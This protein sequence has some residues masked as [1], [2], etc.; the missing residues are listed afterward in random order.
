MP[1]VL[2]FFFVTGAPGPWATSS[3]LPPA[4]NATRVAADTAPRLTLDDALQIAL[5]N[6]DRLGAAGAARDAAEA[7][8]GAAK[9]G[10]LPRIDFD[11]TFS[12]TTNPAL[13]FTNRLGQEAF[14]PLDF[15]IDRLNNPDPLT[16]WNSALSLSYPVYTGG[17]VAG[18]LEAARAGLEAADADL[19]RTRQEV[20]RDVVDAFSTA[21]LAEAHLGVARE[22]LETARANVALVSDLRDAGLVVESDLLQAR[23][24]EIEVEEMVIRAEAGVQVARAAV[25]LNLGRDLDTPFSPSPTLEETRGPE[26]SLDEL[27]AEAV[28]NRPDLRAAEAGVRA[29][30]ESRRAARAGSKPEVGL[31]GRFEANDEQFIGAQGTNWSVFVAARIPIYQ[32]KQSRARV[33]RAE[34]Q[35]REAQRMRDRLRQSIDLE[36]RRAYFDVRASRKSLEQSRRAVELARES[37]RSVQD[38]YREG[39]TTLVELLDAETA[40]TRSRTREIATLRELIVSQANLELAVGRL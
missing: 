24:R 11:E 38:R 4:P 31:Q 34:A 33:A 26:V 12:W 32:G 19:E 15:D 1:A 2:L 7:G 37:L 5:G 20:V 16:N 18:V 36:T 35:T 14:T 27:V 22:S 17:R 23:V 25:N 9:S 10:R 40:L 21:V 6:N 30:G 39:L 29:A 13:V 8:V 28:A 3:P